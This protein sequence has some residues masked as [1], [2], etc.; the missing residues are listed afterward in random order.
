MTEAAY[1]VV[2]LLQTFPTIQLPPGERIDL[3]GREKQ[4]TTLVLRIGV[5]CNVDL[6]R[7]RNGQ[8]D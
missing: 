1:T 5:G 7:A 4:D 8:T 6:F 2:R 3:V